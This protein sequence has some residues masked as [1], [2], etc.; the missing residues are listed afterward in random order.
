MKVTLAAS[1]PV[2]QNHFFSKTADRIF[3]KFHSFGV[4]RKKL[5]IS[6]K[7]GVLWSWQKTYSI[8]MLFLGLHDT[9]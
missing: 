5:E 3:M 4:L 7:V 1:Q 6:L 9:P 8:D 2:S